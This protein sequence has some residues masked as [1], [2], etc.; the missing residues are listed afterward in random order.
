LKTYT[1]GPSSSSGILVIY[2]IFGF[3]P[4]TIQGADILSGLHHKDSES[5]RKFKIFMP[6]F[7]EGKP[8]DISW[9]PPDTDEKG[10]KL[11]EFFQ[12]TAA[13]PAPRIE[14]GEVAR[15]CPRVRK[16]P[17]VTSFIGSPCRVSIDNASMSTD[18]AAYTP[19]WT[20]RQSRGYVSRQKL[21]HSRSLKS[22]AVW[23]MEVEGLAGTERH[24]NSVKSL[25]RIPSSQHRHKESMIASMCCGR[26]IR[27]DGSFALGHFNAG[28][29]RHL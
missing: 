2:D 16:E 4:Q 13:P 19:S 28:P 1:T 8:A 12:T 3:F 10:K 18:S 7:F 9:Y 29:P 15:Q 22:M 5:Q 23:R 20:Q 14:K 26:V 21:K 24:K 6:D 27:C 17:K 25:Y 11:G